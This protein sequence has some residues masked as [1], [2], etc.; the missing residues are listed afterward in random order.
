[1]G[2][3][4]SPETG[5]KNKNS[6]PAVQNG[7]PLASVFLGTESGKT[8]ECYPVRTHGYRQQ[9]TATQ[10]NHPKR[11]RASRGPEWVAICLMPLAVA[12]EE[13]RIKGQSSAISYIPPRTPLLTDKKKC[14]KRMTRAVD[15]TG[16]K[17]PYN[18]LG[19]SE[20]SHPFAPTPASLPFSHY[21]KLSSSPSRLLLY[22]TTHPQVQKQGKN[23]CAP[24]AVAARPVLTM[25]SL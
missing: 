10:A 19:Q 14:G 15:T 25:S 23:S 9:G 4:S 2:H 6:F 11:F 21:R 5:S 12:S 17:D 13:G 18:S 7:G 16:R 3:R 24:E 20:S 1:M 22:P 8:V